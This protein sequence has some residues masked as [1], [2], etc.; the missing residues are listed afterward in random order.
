MSTS[1]PRRLAVVGSGV[2]GLTAAYVASRPGNDVHV[3]VLEADDRLGGHADTHDVTDAAGRALRIDSGFIVHNRRTY[4]VL[5]RLFDELG[6]PTQD[7]EMSM[8]ISDERTGLE[9]AGALGRRGLFPSGA[10]NHRNPAY[11]RMLAEVPR[12]HRA[13]RRLLA[14][15]PGDLTTLAAFLDHGGFSPYFRRHFAEPLVAAVWSCDPDTALDYPAAYLF[16]FLQHHGMLAVFGS[17]TWRTVTG[18]S[19][20][21][22][23]RV[24]DAIRASGGTIRTGTPVLSIEE[25][26][27]GVEVST[28]AGRETYDAVVV[29]THPDQALGMLSAPTL[30]QKEV[31][32]AIP[33]STNTALLHTD[34]RLMPRARDAWASWNFRRP[35]IAQ[36]QVQVTYDLTRLQR[37]PTDTPYLVTLGGEDVVDPA[38]VL[39]RRDYA[40][41]RYT[42]ASVAA[43]ARLPEIDTDRL[44]F[45]GAYHGWGFHEDGARSGLHAAERLGLAWE[46]A[47]APAATSY[48]TTLVHRRREP[49]RNAFTLRS[50]LSVVDLDRVA[51]DGTV[52]GVPGR[53]EGRDHFAGDTASVRE[54]LDR[55]LAEHGLDAGLRGGRALMAAQPRAFGHCFNP[56]SVHWCWPPGRPDG[57]PAAT[58][59]E[60]HNTY[61]DRHA[62]LLD[63]PATADG[64]VVV[65]K[66]MYVS[67]FHGTDGHYEVLAPPPDPEDHRLRIAV[68]LVTE[69]GAR[70]DAA[71]DGTPAA[72]PRLPL[73]GLRGAALI[74]AH[75]IALWARR[76][77]VQPRRATVQTAQTPQTA[78]A[79][80][81][82]GGFAARV[83]ERLFRAAIG[84]LDVTVRLEHADGR[85]EELGRGGPAIV[86]HRPDEMFARTGRD[87]LIGFGEAYLTGAWAED[88]VPGDGVLG[89]FLTVLAA[90]LT[91]LVPRPLQRLRGVVVTRLPQS[92]RGTRDNTQANVAHHYD[93]S[94]DLFAAFL[95]PTL[96]YSSALFTD[97]DPAVAATEDLVAAQHRKID[98]LLDQAGVGAGTRLLEIGTGW[99]ELAIRAAA[100]GADVRSITLS[101]EQQELARERIAAAGQADRV[102]VDLCDYRALLDEP[103]AAYDAVVSVEMIEAVGQEFWPAYFRTLDHVLAPGG[104]VAI[105]AITM[106]HDRMLATRSTHTFITK[107]VFPGGALPSVRAIDE[108]TRAHTTLRIT[109]DLAIGPHY[110]TTLRR[111]DT[112]F[113]ASRDRVRALG[114]DTTFE[115]MWHFYLEYCRAG[116]AAGYID[117]HQLTFT[118]PDEESR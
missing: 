72:P 117:D 35:R 118:R 96:S 41:P 50:H 44:V 79:P 68:R 25:T 91:T 89:A 57:D 55:F 59:V 69:D 97:P 2:A 47:G 93:L 4:P 37:L 81:R 54:G 107:Y 48:A 22:V 87:Q 36:E 95:D 17:P 53:F 106:P 33:Y 62:Y 20:A 76:V 30:L 38:T 14:N 24:A 65:D 56:I 74:R 13:A 102:R 11:L 43:Q 42:P 39:V 94:N 49:V 112:A 103:G 86:V 100:R 27:D 3:T 28:A 31:L 19:G 10:G 111:W 40:H 105:Q 85:T 26:G 23:A 46:D 6:V 51:P 84:R 75:G 15:G 109:D 77:P 32:D 99:G 7:S 8:S 63:G 114:F 52:D 101:V 116:F 16:A 45:A 80:I 5:G 70:F 67:P 71:L 90:E 113:V 58:V 78:L 82:T 64:R 98:R 104:R 34:A 92:Q 18:G 60:V 115:R 21:Y 66:A 83:A 9:W 108:V 61:G 110:A 29:A 1:T 73:A 12:F 88:G